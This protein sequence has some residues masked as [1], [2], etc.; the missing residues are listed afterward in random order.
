MQSHILRFSLLNSRRQI[1]AEALTLL[2]WILWISRNCRDIQPLSRHVLHYDAR[3]P[4]PMFVPMKIECKAIFC[5]SPCL[6][7]GARSLRKLWRSQIE[8]YE[9]HATHADRDLKQACL[10]YDARVPLP[11]LVLTKIE[12][13]AIFCG[14]PCLIAGTRSLRKL[15]RSQIE[16]YESHATAAIYSP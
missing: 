3:V 1:F 13:K 7:A 10:Y 15:W 8:C 6:I 16:C 11:M 9:S 2:D 14:S 5:G 12:C 4:L